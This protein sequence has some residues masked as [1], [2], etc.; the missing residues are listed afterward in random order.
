MNNIIET[1]FGKK[2][3]IS[4]MANGSASNITKQGTFYVFSIRLDA[5]DVR[6]YSFTDRNRAV[7]MRQVLIGH[8]EQKLLQDTKKRAVG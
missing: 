7:S 2:V 6:E 4:R 1:N 5:D 3:D 8:I